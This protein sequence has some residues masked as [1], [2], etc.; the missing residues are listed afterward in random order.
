MRRT[1]TGFVFTLPAM[2]SEVNASPLLCAIK[3]NAWVATTNRLL[4]VITSE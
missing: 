3:V 4:L 1:T 2:Y